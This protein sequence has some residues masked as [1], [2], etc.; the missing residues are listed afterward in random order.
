MGTKPRWLAG[1]GT[2][3]GVA[4]A[5]GVEVAVGDGIGVSVGGTIG[6]GVAGGGRVAVGG[7]GVGV[8]GASPQPVRSMARAT[9]RVSR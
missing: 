5:A 8:D 9:K 6:V 7:R 2:N 4:V 1:I 3:S